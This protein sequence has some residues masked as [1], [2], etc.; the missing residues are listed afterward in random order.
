M[1]DFRPGQQI[2]YVPTHAAGDLTHADVEFGFVTGPA[3]DAA[4][5]CRY[6][7]P[8]RPGELRTVANSEATPADLL[9]S[10]E[11]VPQALVDDLL[12]RLEG[13]Y[14]FPLWTNLN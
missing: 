4:F 1:R 12:R 5:F 10:R 8:G 2:A 9:I 7:R 13:F 3:G 11:S 6:W 14:G